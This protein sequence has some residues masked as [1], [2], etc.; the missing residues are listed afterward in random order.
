MSPESSLPF[1]QPDQYKYC[2]SWM[3][4]WSYR[5]QNLVKEITK[6]APDFMCLQVCDRRG[7]A[8]HNVE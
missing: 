3:L 6:Y 4:S 5:K 8:Q 7:S 2:Q 1:V